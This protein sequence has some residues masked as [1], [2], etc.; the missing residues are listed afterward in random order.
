MLGQLIR[1]GVSWPQPF[2]QVPG[3]TRVKER[4]TI[5]ERQLAKVQTTE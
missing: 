5:L 3:V 2:W 1:Q 4:V